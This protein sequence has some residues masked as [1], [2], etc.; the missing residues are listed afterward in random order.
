MTRKYKN[1]SVGRSFDD[2]T[3]SICERSRWYVSTYYK[4]F[5]RGD[6]LNYYF[7]MN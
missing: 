1:G 4:M 5:L 6:K 3:G 2:F 7:V